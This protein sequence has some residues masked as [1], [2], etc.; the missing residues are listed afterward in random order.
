[1]QAEHSGVSA[2]FNV[3][4]NPGGLNLYDGAGGTLGAA[5]LIV[6]NSA[7]QPL[8]GSLVVAPDRHSVTWVATKDVLAPGTYSVALKSGAAAFADAQGH[9]L[10][11]D[12]DGASGGDFL[13]QF[14]VPSLGGRVLSLPDAA[15]GAGQAVAVPAAANGWP[16][17]LDHA[18]GVTAFAFDALYDP[19][20]LSI[21]GG[22]R[23]AGLPADWTVT[24]DVGTPGAAKVT[25]TGS[26]TLSGTHV[27]LVRL[28]ANVSSSVAYG[29]SQAVRLDSVS[30][31]GGGIAAIGDVAVHKAAYLGDADGSGIH[32]AA[33]AFLVVQAALGLAS[34]FAAHAWTDPRIVGDADG[35]GVL[36]AADAFL[37]VQEGLGLSEPFVPDNPRV[38][39]TPVGGGVDPQFRID[40]AI[41]AAAGGV[42]T[43]PARLDIEAAATNV[44]GIDFEL[45]F[46]PD[47][48]TIDVP[49]GVAG[50][51]DTAA[52]WALSA[53]L[54][55][56]GQLR[57]GLLGG[58]GQ[59]LAAGLREIALLQFHVAAS[60]RDAGLAGVSR[61]HV[62]ELHIEPIDPRAG[63]YTWTAVDGSLAV[64][65][66]NAWHVERTPDSGSPLLTLDSPAT[67]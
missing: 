28:L 8:A 57:V 38:P 30:L 62:A 67:Y 14:T 25:A 11:G 1:L 27:E 51:A 50:G 3:P 31:N 12:G 41:P 48:L 44:G 46:N 52:G 63:G 16:V 29:G 7:G 32:S 55:A 6:Q 64:A 22:T 19:G 2:S 34:G 59:P 54:V 33:D 61:R 26:T 23:A 60:L 9:A 42:V 18:D 66:V 53:Q 24:V 37:I 17:F 21:S 39:L 13:G 40:T 65:A 20:L 58:Q 47:V 15:V 35:S 56:P 10:D 43:V 36:S 45:F 5:D 4:L 49:Q